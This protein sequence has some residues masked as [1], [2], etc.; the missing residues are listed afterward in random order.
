[1]GADTLYR[2]KAS[3]QSQP[4]RCNVGYTRV[5]CIEALRDTVNL[6]DLQLHCKK[7]MG[8]LPQLM[9]YKKFQ[10]E[11]QLTNFDIWYEIIVTNLLKQLYKCQ[12]C[13]KKFKSKWNLDQ[14]KP[15]HTGEKKHVCVCGKGFTQKASLYK[16]SKKNSC[17]ISQ[18]E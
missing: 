13:N 1:M 4:N 9:G 3:Q 2:G 15:V 5:N 16:H 18:V 10:R 6:Y 11:I 8:R 17:A 12:L 7:Q 14:H